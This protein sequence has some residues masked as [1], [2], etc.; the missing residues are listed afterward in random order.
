MSILGIL[1]CTRSALQAIGKK[2]LPIMSSVI[3]LIG[4]IL[5]VIFLIPHF[6]YAAVIVCEPVIWLFMDIE[7]VL[8]F[9]LN[10]YIRG[11]APKQI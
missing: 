3:E 1:N 8:A 5:F 10:P 4:K 6:G 2:V 9:W 11:K 7:L